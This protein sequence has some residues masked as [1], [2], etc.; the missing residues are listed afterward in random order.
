M[1]LQTDRRPN[2]KWPTDAARTTTKPGR[3]ANGARAATARA[4]DN[5]S[6]CA[7][8]EEPGASVNAFFS[9]KKRGVAGTPH[10][11]TTHTHTH[12][13]KIL[14]ALNMVLVVFGVEAGGIFSRCARN[15]S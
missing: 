14:Y 10:A 9:I 2:D 15:D 12:N 1:R 13:L 3:N 6:R 7:C 8:M 11:D 5:A 4:R